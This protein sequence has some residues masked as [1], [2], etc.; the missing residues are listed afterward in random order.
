MKFPLKKFI[1]V[2][3]L[4]IFLLNGC[5]RIETANQ[6]G[7]FTSAG[8]TANNSGDKNG[9]QTVKDDV[10]ELGKIVKLPYAPEEATYSEINSGGKKLIAVLKFSSEDAARI[11]AQAEKYKSPAPTDVDAEDWFPPELVAKSQETGDESLKGVEYAANDFL[12]SPYAAGKL[13]RIN[14]AD[15]F[16]LELTTF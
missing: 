5:S 16:V 2:F 15:Y 3:S 10:E 8:Q 14:E 11:V 7:N 13:T 1:S 4:G 9:V 12:Q 6:N